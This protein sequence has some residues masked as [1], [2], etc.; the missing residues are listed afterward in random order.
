MHRSHLANGVNIVTSAR[1]GATHAGVA[2]CLIGGVRAQ[3]AAESGY[4]HLVEHLL[5]ESGEWT[6]SLGQSQ[7]TLNA[8]TG[9]EHI[10]LTGFVLAKDA[11]RLIERFAQSLLD[12]RFS[13]AAI[14]AERG[15]IALEDEQSLLSPADRAEQA[16]V[17][18]I[19]PGHAI[20]QPLSGQVKGPAATTVPPLQRFWQRLSRSQGTFVFGVGAIDHGEIKAAA[21]ALLSLP[22][23]GAPDFG[24]SPCF[25]SSARREFGMADGTRLLWVLPM[26]APNEEAHAAAELL[27]RL[28]ADAAQ[29]SGSNLH[30]EARVRSAGV[31]TRLLRYSDAS[32]L[33][34]ELE[35]SAVDAAHASRACEDTFAQL[36]A[37]GFASD[38]FR[39][40]LR[41]LMADQQLELNRLDCQLER[42]AESVLL[43]RDATAIAT[44]ECAN[45]VFRQAWP[46]HA[47][48]R[49]AASS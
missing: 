22:A 43:R 33:V 11:A 4:A 3:T 24:S 48:L 46:R 5:F 20:A 34:V 44:L 31:A 26:P 10:A 14:D 21:R 8:Y 37:K 39:R 38:A 40:A 28:L 29:S 6:G 35:T 13:D 1:A 36:A 19:W 30:S 41:D 47:K 42:L 9:R 7:S 25:A 23:A 2:L 16:I 45:D 27:Q 12:V 49:W 15:R 18:T 32:A 17:E